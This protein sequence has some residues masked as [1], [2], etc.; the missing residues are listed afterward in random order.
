MPLCRER[1]MKWENKWLLFFPSVQVPC[2]IGQRTPWQ[3]HRPGFG[4]KLLVL[5]GSSGKLS[6]DLSH[7][8]GWHGALCLSEKKVYSEKHTTWIRS[9][10]IIQSQHKEADRVPL[11]TTEGEK[12]ILFFFLLSWFL[13]TPLWTAVGQCFLRGLEE[14]SCVR[15]PATQNPG[16]G[17][18]SAPSPLCNCPIDIMLFCH[19]STNSRHVKSRSTG[20]ETN[21]F[22]SH[23]T[24]NK[25]CFSG[26]GWGSNAHL[27]CSL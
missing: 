6:W 16:V 5:R 11:A 18:H 19:P 9:K 10:I 3:W 15:Q 1:L 8:A 2:V 25:L 22:W 12:R 7:P 13:G 14:H 24:W 27:P 21:S 20:L 17:A 23:A 26:V 4:E